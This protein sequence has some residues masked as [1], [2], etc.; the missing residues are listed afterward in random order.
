MA[1]Q[2]RKIIE[3]AYR[4]VYN[5]SESKALLKRDDKIINDAV[6]KICRWPGYLPGEKDDAETVNSRELDKKAFTG[7]ITDLCAYFKKLGIYDNK[8]KD[9]G[10]IFS[11]YKNYVAPDPDGSLHPA[12]NG[13]KE[14]I[15]ADDITRDE[16]TTKEDA[17]ETVIEEPIE[18]PK[19]IDKEKLIT[20][21]E[22]RMSVNPN[23][24]VGE[25]LEDD[26]AKAAAQ[27][28]QTA[29]AIM[30]TTGAPV[31]TGV[32]TPS[33]DDANVAAANY[34]QSVEQARKAYAQENHVQK[35]LISQEPLSKRIPQDIEEGICAD[36]KGRRDAIISKV[37]AG[38]QKPEGMVDGM[39]AGEYVIPNSVSALNQSVEYIEFMT[40]LNAACNNPDHKFAIRRSS[41]LAPFKGA[42][43]IEHGKEIVIKWA[44]L[45]TLLY[46]K[47]M[48]QLTVEGAPE[49]M[50][51]LGKARM[52]EGKKID[53]VNDMLVVNVVGKSNLIDANEGEVK[54]TAHVDF[55]YKT[56]DKIV[57]DKT[58][59]R[60]K[61]GF[62]YMKPASSTDK[63]A[64][65][66]KT[67][68]NL[69]LQVPQ[70]DVVIAAAIY[71]PL[72]VSR[73]VGNVV[74]AYSAEQQA[75]V[76]TALFAEV[77]MVGKASDGLQASLQETKNTSQA[78]DAEQ[79]A[80]MA[81]NG[82]F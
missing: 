14:K 16:H 33:K 66:R 62:K 2:A 56:T 24:T 43:I 4:G 50:A 17:S 26:F 19:S 45:K 31:G 30:G 67:N 23:T 25:V 73:G 21:E 79:A 63:E 69:T 78:A 41:K 58:G 61:V 35:F 80:Q 20:Q 40:E 38:Q 28:K 32:G 51:Q 65:E 59:V 36:P 76:M 39:V 27:A 18:A 75:S 3:K 72:K 48:T 52:T 8:L 81:I 77:V 44:D 46:E 37:W 53:S 13:L 9:W 6:M 54:D 47:T 29:A 64:K 22:E 70:Y 5:I 11:I 71:D 68:V 7:D 42:Q 49:M 57:N 74:T 1:R 60:S 55:I 12:D 15:E 82:Q 34:V 10:N